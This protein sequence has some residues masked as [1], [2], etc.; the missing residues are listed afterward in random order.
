MENKLKIGRGLGDLSAACD[1]M[2]VLKDI[3]EKH[4]SHLYRYALMILADH[5]HAQ[6]AVQQVFLKAM[7]RGKRILEIASLESYLRKAVRNECYEILKKR[8]Q[9]DNV[10]RLLSCEPILEKT[11]GATIDED[12]QKILDSAIRKL[13]PDQREVLY[14]KVYEDKTFSEIALITGV[15]TNTAASRYRY[16]MDKLKETLTI[17]G[18]NF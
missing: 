10:A 1:H 2:A 17:H 18:I 13:P 8:R 6:D 16:A 9:A 11:P 15:S 5:A 4:G 3:Y 14:M 12:E 7:K